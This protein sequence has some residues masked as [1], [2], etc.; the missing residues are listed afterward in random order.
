MKKIILT[1]MVLAGVASATTFLV[2]ENDSTLRHY[3]DGKE[4][5]LVKLSFNV[6]GAEPAPALIT[7][8]AEL[9]GWEML[10]GQGHPRPIIV[11][12]FVDGDIACE[13][14]HAVVNF[15]DA[16]NVMDCSSV[17]FWQMFLEPGQ[18]TVEITVSG[19][20][21]GVDYPGAL[22]Q[23]RYDT[24]DS[25]SMVCEAYNEDDYKEP[26]TPSLI[27]TSNSVTVPGAVAVYDKT[28]RKVD[29]I[30]DDLVIMDGLPAGQYFVQTDASATATLKII[31]T[32]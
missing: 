12:L 31:K 7:F 9:A 4:M 6:G 20:V 2:Q 23:V 11:K 29:V 10:M 22:L 15:D 30:R 21:K 18:H 17:G 32:R 13:K 28:G 27:A 16:Y 19:G 8:N 5:S 24:Q 26:Y 25:S 3:T 14:T 1:L